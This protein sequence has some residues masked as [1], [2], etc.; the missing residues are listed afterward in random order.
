MISWFLEL[1]YLPVTQKPRKVL[2]NESLGSVRRHL[3]RHLLTLV[4]EEELFWIIGLP[5]NE[6]ALHPF[7]RAMNQVQFA[8]GREI[9]LTLHNGCNAESNKTAVKS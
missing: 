3:G 6:V 9:L 8:K 1:L 2:R 4:P 7:T 5:T